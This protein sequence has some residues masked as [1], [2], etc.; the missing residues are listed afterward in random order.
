MLWSTKWAYVLLKFI[1]TLNAE[2][3]IVSTIYSQLFTTRNKFRIRVS[4]RSSRS[5]ERDLIRTSS[6][7][8]ACTMTN[9]RANVSD[10]ITGS[11][12]TGSRYIQQTSRRVPRP[13]WCRHFETQASRR[14]L[15]SSRVPPNAY[16]ETGS[17]SRREWMESLP[18]CDTHRN[19]RATS[20]FT[21]CCT[22]SSDERFRFNFNFQRFADCQGGWNLRQ[23]KLR[24]VERNRRDCAKFAASTNDRSNSLTSCHARRE[25]FVPKL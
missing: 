12:D 20:V 22:Y 8:G 2:E 5:R 15:H 25:F 24:F 14:Y 1:N 17:F 3:L 16:D 4:T 9:E 19:H 21:R 23:R 10:V 18:C 13:L 6:K 11:V 7:I